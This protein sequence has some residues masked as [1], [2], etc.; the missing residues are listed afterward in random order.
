MPTK[1]RKKNEKRKKRTKFY[2]PSPLSIYITNLKS[3]LSLKNNVYLFHTVRMY[4][5]LNFIDSPLIHP[6]NL[7]SIILILYLFMKTWEIP[8]YF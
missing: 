2:T 8:L 6:H 1:L 5:H 4:Y 7:K 3:I